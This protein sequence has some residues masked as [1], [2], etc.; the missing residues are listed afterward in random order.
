MGNSPV[1]V[2]ASFVA[3]LF[4][5]PEETQAWELLDRWT[6]E[7]TPICSPTF[8]VYELTNVLYRYQRAGY[9]SLAT[10]GLVL[11]AASELP[12]RLEPHASLTSAALR[13][14]ANLGLPATYDA[15]YLA[16]AARHDAEL[17]TAD[18]RLERQ[19]GGQVCRVKVLG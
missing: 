3:R 8:L 9:L 15:F 13:I 4:M 18:T 7:G 14:A 17:W 5:G 12:L 19:A 16:L 11:D 1:C 10:T 2:D 6:G